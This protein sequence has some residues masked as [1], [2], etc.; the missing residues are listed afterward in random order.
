MNERSDTITMRILIVEDEEDMQ[1]ILRLYLEKEGH[2]VS[3]A[4]D[5]REAFDCV[6]ETRFD[7]A[8]VDWMMPR[9]DGVAF[10]KRVREYQLPIKIIM[11]TAKGE[12]A[13]EIAGLTCGADD[14]MKKPFE[15]KILMLR[16]RKMFQMDRLLKCGEVELNQETQIAKKGNTELKLTQKEYLLLQT[17]LINKGIIL[18][19]D[20][21]L[22][23]IWGEEYEG[24]ER[25]LDTHVRRLRNKIGTEWISTHIGLGYRMDELNE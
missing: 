10:C 2:E 17:F 8:V 18:S 1:K 11:L 15:P 3:V 23:K 22:E 25:T 20:Q 16:I 14:Y 13:D 9:M 4:K 19:R 24:D 21:L 6:C 7:L 5:G 12:T